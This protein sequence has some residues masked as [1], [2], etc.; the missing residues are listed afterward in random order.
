MIADLRPQRPPSRPPRPFTPRISPPQNET[1]P[2][3]V[4]RS[5][6]SSTRFL[7]LTLAVPMLASFA[8]ADDERP[9]IEPVRVTT[10]PTIDGVLD[11]AAWQGPPLPLTEW[12]TYNPLNGD[13]LEQR[14]EVRAVYDD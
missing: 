4:T 5:M 9:R 14:T 12:L 2:A 11:D 3:S 1:E 7:I 10:P 6:Q 13:R 8:R